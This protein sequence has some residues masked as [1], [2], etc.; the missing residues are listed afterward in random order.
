MSDYV[1]ILNEAISAAESGPVD[2]GDPAANDTRPDPELLAALREAVRVQGLTCVLQI[3]QP[4][5][6]RVIETLHDYPIPHGVTIVRD[7]QIRIRAG[8]RDDVRLARVVDV[9]IDGYALIVKV[10]V[11]GTMP[12]DG[13]EPEGDSF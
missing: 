13:P 9:V 8:N 6:Y 7:M 4:G 1:S 11:W 2:A 3:V 12:P 10:T 5:R